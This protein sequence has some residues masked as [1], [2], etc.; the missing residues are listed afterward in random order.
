MSCPLI[1]A[2][3]KWAFMPYYLITAR[4]PQSKPLSPAR[5]GICLVK[6]CKPVAFHGSDLEWGMQGIQC[7]ARRLSVLWHPFFVCRAAESDVWRHA[8]QI[9]IHACDGDGRNSTDFH[10][11]H[12]SGVQDRAKAMR[13]KARR[14][15]V[16]MPM[17]YPPYDLLAS[18]RKMA[19]K[20]SLVRFA[21]S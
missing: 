6:G 8:F 10:S 17:P 7:C 11:C 5:R 4:L 1:F 9:C 21:S 18:H 3:L 12:P 19:R 14:S 13:D 15:R 2:K 20:I 16:Q